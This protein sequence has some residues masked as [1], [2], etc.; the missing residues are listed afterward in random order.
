MKFLV[1]FLTIFA[2]SQSYLLNNK[3]RLGIGV[4]HAPKLGDR[5]PKEE[6]FLQKLDHFN[7]TDETTWLQVFP[8]FLSLKYSNIFSK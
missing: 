4:P 5:L 3:N 7:P 8:P 2:F 1:Y 6:Y